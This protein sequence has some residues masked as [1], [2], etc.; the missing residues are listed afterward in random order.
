MPVSYVEREHADELTHGFYDSAEV[1]SWPH[2]RSGLQV[3]CRLREE[4]HQSL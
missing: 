4:G 1:Y 2:W 3:W